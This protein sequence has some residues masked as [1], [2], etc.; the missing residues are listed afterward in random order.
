MIQ[1]EAQ[2]SMNEIARSSGMVAQLLTK[3]I[4]VYSA[5]Q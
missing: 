4:P 3:T 5:Q 2:A 1:E